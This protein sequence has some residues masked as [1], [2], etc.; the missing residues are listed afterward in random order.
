M[1]HN[2]TCGQ[3]EMKSNAKPVFFLISQ[4][5]TG[6]STSRTHLHLHIDI[7]RAMPQCDIFTQQQSPCYILPQLASPSAHL[8][9]SCM[10]IYLSQQPQ[11]S[12]GEVQIVPCAH[13]IQSPRSGFAPTFF[14]E[15]ARRSSNGIFRPRSTGSTSRRATRKPRST[16][17]HHCPTRA[18]AL[19]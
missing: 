3:L 14:S 5:Q 13:L 8:L 19:C 1:T 7:D 12:G 6:K 10:C 17:R 2:M 15:A 9:R 18:V 16:G 11:T 4:L